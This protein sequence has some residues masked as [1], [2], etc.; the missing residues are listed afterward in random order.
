[1]LSRIN[2]DYNAYC[3]YI[4]MLLNQGRDEVINPTDLEKYPKGS[5]VSYVN[6]NGKFRHGGLL[7]GLTEDYIIL[8]SMQNLKDMRD[9]CIKLNN[10]NAFYIIDPR[11]VTS[12]TR[13]FSFRHI[14]DAESC[15]YTVKI[16]DTI[17]FKGRDTY[18]AER[19][20]TTRKYKNQLE[21][22]DQF[23]KH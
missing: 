12:K 1:M 16:G 8:R 7:V 4:D 22:Y 23:I 15:K 21:Y 17:V 5:V 13:S 2:C 20:K 10:I 18:D 3:K 11:N 14:D 9:L 19:Y 6:K